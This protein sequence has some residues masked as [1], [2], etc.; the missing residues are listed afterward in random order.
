MDQPPHGPLRDSK[1]TGTVG[2][3]AT[4]TRVFH[5]RP[6]QGGRASVLGENGVH[7]VV[8]TPYGVSGVEFLHLD[9]EGEPVGAQRLALS[10]KPYGPL[11]SPTTQHVSTTLQGHGAKKPDDS[12]VVVGVKVREE[13]V[14]EGKGDAVAHHLALSSFAAVE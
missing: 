2:I 3:E 8:S 12:Q 5:Q 1:L 4:P 6:T 13:D 14:R 7:G 9:R 11:G 10:Q